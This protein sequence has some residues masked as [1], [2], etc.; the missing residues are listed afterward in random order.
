MKRNKE[1]SPYVIILT[2][3]LVM[4]FLGGIV[5][6]LPLSTVDG[7]GTGFIDG[8]FTATSAV[9][10]TGLTINDVSS[11]YNL[12]G[13]TV[14]LMLIQLGALGFITFSSMF[15]LL[16]TKKISYYTKKV[17]QED[18]NTE[19]L[20]DIQNYI[21]KVMI[22]VFGIEFV[23]A[24]FLFFEFIQKFEFKRAVYY[25]LFHSISA[26]CNAGFSLFPDSLMSF[27]GSAVINISVPLLIF[28]G[29][30]GFAT[31]MN[32]YRYF[33]GKD[34]R[35]TTNSKVSINISIFLIIAGTILIFFT[36]YSNKLTMGNYTIYEKIGAS[37]FQS[38]STRTAGFNTISLSEMKSSTTFLFIILMFIG[39]S[40]GS[41][42]GGIKTT[43]IGLIILGIRNIID[44]REYLEIN[45][46]RINWHNFNKAVAVIT[47][48]L[49]YITVILFVMTSIE[50]NMNF[51]NLLF[52][53]VSAFGTVGLTRGI[54]P[55]LSDVSKIFII[56]TM[57]IG[58]VG[59]LT[60]TL[61]LISKKLKKGKYKYPEENLLIG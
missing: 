30:I 53:I 59:P 26:F 46:R 18:L 54:T 2:S 27:K 8:I 50:K 6:S 47:I 23:G 16:V 55:L 20:F 51:E 39:A 40:P 42:G 36:E 38:V 14:I 49:T 15:V 3:F 10:V 56:L 4:I 44:N 22:T 57:L 17:V 7:K 32:V 28:F 35:L 45:G 34:K 43:T 31:L 9:C 1:I 21:R 60:M 52:E 5:L 25:S 61:V 13:K 29:G 48:S 41:T 19:T 33:R 58:R 12:F 37:F 24:V 11:S